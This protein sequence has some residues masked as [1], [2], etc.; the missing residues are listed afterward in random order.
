MDGK[1]CSK[2]HQCKDLDAFAQRASS[3]DGRHPWC[4]ECMSTY[5]KMYAAQ[6]G[7]DVNRKSRLNREY[8]LSLQGYDT[9]LEFQGG[10]CGICRSEVSDLHRKDGQRYRSMCVDHDHKSGQR[11]GLLCNRCNRAIGLLGDDINLL[12]SAIGYLEHYRAASYRGVESPL[13]PAGR[14]IRPPRDATSSKWRESSG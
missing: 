8:G 6:R 5:N 3:K 11:R 7:R 4:R 14:R 10:G 13:V 12:R 2:C 9:L 1:T